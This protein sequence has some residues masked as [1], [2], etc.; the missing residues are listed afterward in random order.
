[1]TKTMYK[2]LDNRITIADSKINGQGVFAK[3][4]IPAGTNLGI[5]HYEDTRSEDGYIRTPL[6]GF[7][8]HS[9]E[10]NCRKIELGDSYELWTLREVKQ[11]EELTAHYTLY[12][13]TQTSTE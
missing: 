13:P 12:T 7:Y 9:E 4:N 6:G 1:M 11:G 3:A 2:P 5:T 8:N 10:P